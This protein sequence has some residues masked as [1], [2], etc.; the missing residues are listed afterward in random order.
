MSLG[1]D[2]GDVVEALD[3]SVKAVL[4]VHDAGPPSAVQELTALASS[5]GTALS[6]D[7]AHGL[8]GRHRA[9]PLGSFGRMSTMSFHETRNFICGE[10][11]SAR[12]IG[13]ELRIRCAS[14]NPTIVFGEYG[15]IHRRVPR[16]RS[17][18]SLADPDQLDSL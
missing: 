4:T 16:P 10:G 11:G 7:N 2:P 14:V 15:R 5:V 18:D 6:E 13:I 9:A 17:V 3:D 12:A 1:L 8:L